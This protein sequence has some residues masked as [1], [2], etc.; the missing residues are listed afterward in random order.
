MPGP[1]SI[2]VLGL[3][4]SVILACKADTLLLE[5]HLQSILVILEMGGLKNYLPR[6]ASTMILL[7]SASQVARIIGVSHCCLA[8]FFFF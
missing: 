8:Y 5:P 7:I 1:L 6:L 3:Q 2:G 4:V